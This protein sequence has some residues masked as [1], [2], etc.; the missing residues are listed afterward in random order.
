MHARGRVVPPIT[1]MPHACTEGHLKEVVFIKSRFF[2]TRGSFT[3]HSCRLSSCMKEVGVVFSATMGDA[4]WKYE[5][6]RKSSSVCWR[7]DGKW[8]LA[9]L[10][11]LLLQDVAGGGVVRAGVHVVN[12]C[13]M[14]CCFYAWWLNDVHMSKKQAVST[15]CRRNCGQNP[16]KVLPAVPCGSL[17]R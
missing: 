1:P 10:R 14:K 7:K 6:K 3:C 4:G 12:I 8:F 9:S 13:R 5:S 15:L 16:P 17:G 11:S 2:A